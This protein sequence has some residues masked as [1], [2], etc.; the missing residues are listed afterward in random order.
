MRVDCFW[1][2]CMLG[3][4]TKWLRVLGIDVAYQ[5][6]I[7]DAH[8]VQEARLQQ[9][10]ILTRDTRLTQRRWVREHHLLLKD[11]DW[12]P[13]LGQFLHTF[14]LPDQNLWLSRCLRCN[15]LLEDISKEQAAAQVPAYVEQT[16]QKYKRCPTCS[17]I[18]WQGSHKEQMLDELQRII[19]H[20]NP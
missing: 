9:R 7:D 20:L 10:W 17:R 13:Q 11:D 6:A 16:Q 2:D 5:A 19:Q 4:L 12:K 15:S 3:R 8:L 18:Y 1:A 14:G